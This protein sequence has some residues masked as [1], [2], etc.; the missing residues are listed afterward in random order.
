MRSIELTFDAK[1]DAAIRNDWAALSAA[2]LPSLASH[3][4]SSNRPHLTLAA[5]VDL[6]DSASLRSCFAGLPLPVRF[7]GLVVF[8]AGVRRFVLARQVVAASGLLELHRRVHAA[9]PGAVEQ[10]LP[11]RWVPHVTLAR[12]LD[13]AELGTALTLI[14]GPPDLAA[15]A[16]CLWDSAEK[17]ITALH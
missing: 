10:T 17:T 9:A 3:T 6:T 2:G 7:G 4:G 14:G 11:D 15:V 12:R 8:G 5:G 16:A 13:P 1:T